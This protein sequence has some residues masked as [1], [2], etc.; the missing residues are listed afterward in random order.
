MDCRPNIWFRPPNLPHFPFEWPYLFSLVGVKSGIQYN[1][2]NTVHIQAS[3]WIVSWAVAWLIGLY[4]AF[5]LSQYHWFP[6]LNWRHVW[7]RHTCSLSQPI[8][9]C[10][11]AGGV[12]GMALVRIWSGWSHLYI[13]QT[14]N[15]LVAYKAATCPGR[16]SYDD[17]SWPQAL[18]GRHVPWS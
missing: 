15:W 8:S 1:G 14:P 11:M 3:D 13:M 17:C 2:E 10:S 7:H 18:T 6:F 4:K 16:K 5:W 12:W 9:S